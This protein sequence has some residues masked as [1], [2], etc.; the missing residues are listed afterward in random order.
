MNWQERAEKAEAAL[1]EALKDSERL[2]WLTLQFMD[3][4]DWNRIFSAAEHPF[5]LRTTIDNAKD[6]K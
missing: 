2:D 5:D 6:T 4:I 3:D 1:A